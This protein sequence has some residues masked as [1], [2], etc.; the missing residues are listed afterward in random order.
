MDV[1]TDIKVGRLL[2][3]DLREFWPYIAGLVN[4]ACEH[5]DGNYTPTGCVER[6]MQGQWSCWLAMDGGEPRLLAFVG[7]HVYPDTGKRVM[8]IEALGGAVNKTNEDVIAACNA[9]LC[10]YAK[11]RGVD[12]VISDARTGWLKRYPRAFAGAEQIG[13]IVRW[14]VNG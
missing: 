12:D 3:D 9:R 14:S 13:I 6:V 5:S 1:M 10:A 2:P 8:C 7:E 4:L 11:E